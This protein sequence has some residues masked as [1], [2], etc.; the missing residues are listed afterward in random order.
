MNLIERTADGIQKVF[1]GL[2]AEKIA[3]FEAALTFPEDL[4]EHYRKLRA[5]AISKG[6]K[7]PESENQMLDKLL[8]EDSESPEHL[9]KQ[10]LEIRYAVQM[11]FSKL[12]KI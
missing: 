8:G 1:E 9:T 4:I 12:P 10:P 3:E 7:I 6:A 5:N 11:L 2:S